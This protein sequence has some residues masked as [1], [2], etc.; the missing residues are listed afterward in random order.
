MTMAEALAGFLADLARQPALLLAA[1]FIASLLLEDAAIVAA[2]LLAARM[3]VDP[4]A[5]VVVLVLG[6][7][8]G[9]MTLHLAGRGVA[10]HRWIRRQ[11]TRP[12]LERAL[13]WLGRNWWL[14][15]VIARFGPGLRLPVY[16][17]SGILRLPPLACSAVIVAAS[18]VW[19]PGLFLLSR[20]GGAALSSV[21]LY[22]PVAVVLGLAAVPVLARAWRA[23]SPQS[24]S[25]LTGEAPDRGDAWRRE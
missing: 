11:R 22:A 18:L 13:R 17:A 15:L 10:G 5:A 23:S 1:I 2:G 19:T 25:C 12:A 6:T 9:D 21:S 20:A 3:A 24:K 16:L 7:T 14:A 8:A 4:V